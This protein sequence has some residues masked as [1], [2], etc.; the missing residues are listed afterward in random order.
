[1]CVFGRGSGKLPLATC[2]LI[3]VAIAVVPAV[4]LLL[5]QGVF[6]LRGKY[7]NMHTLTHTHIY[8]HA[9]KEIVAFG[10]LII[11]PTWPA[12]SGLPIGKLIRTFDQANSP[13]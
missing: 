12:R 4:V 7:I 5:W 13:L 10:C 1:M 2:Q 3:G 11:G 6:Q 9:N 8:T